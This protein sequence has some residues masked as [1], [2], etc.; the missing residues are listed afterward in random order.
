MLSPDTEGKTFCLKIPALVVEKA[1]DILCGMAG[2]QNDTAG[3]VGSFLHPLFMPFSASNF[4]HIFL[5]LRRN[6]VCNPCIEMHL[7]AV[8]N[9][10]V[11]DVLHNLRKAVTSYMRMRVDK[12]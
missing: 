10:A 12:N 4:P 6:Q 2:S 1:V 7:S 5:T 9:D 3:A 8:G 11:T